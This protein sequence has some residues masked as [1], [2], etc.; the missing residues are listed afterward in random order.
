VL[1]V[2]AP[3]LSEAHEAARRKDKMRGL[4]IIG[5]TFVLCILFSLWGKEMAEPEV[6]QPP[7]P[8]TSEGV[9]GWPKAVEVVATLAAAREATPRANLRG[10]VAERVKSD[11]TIDFKKPGALVRYSFQSGP[12][13]GPQPTLEPGTLPRRSYCG[14]QGVYIRRH[15]LVV[16]A[17]MPAFPCGVH[18]REAMPDPGCSLKQ[19]WDFVTEKK[20]VP[21]KA[22]ARIEYYQAK[23]GPAYRFSV[24]GTEHRLA[25]SADCSRLLSSADGLGGVP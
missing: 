7:R 5:V 22:P 13:E 4:V 18:L 21:T 16:D 24:P 1:Q 20:G 11:G 9:V 8:P 15:G 12:G 10:F 17:D 2:L 23:S 3:H 19:V 6:S 25:L 14:K